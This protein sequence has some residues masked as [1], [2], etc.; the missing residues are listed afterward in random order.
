MQRT[1]DKWN[2]IVFWC[3][4]SWLHTFSV[5]DTRDCQAFDSPDIFPETLLSF[6][7]TK[8]DKVHWHDLIFFPKNFLS[9]RNPSV[10]SHRSPFGMR[11]PRTKGWKEKVI[12]QMKI[13]AFFRVSAAWQILQSLPAKIRIWGYLQRKVDPSEGIDL[14]WKFN[15]VISVQNMF[16]CA[17]LSRDYATIK[18]QFKNFLCDL[19]LIFKLRIFRYLKKWN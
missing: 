1:Q 10:V 5:S 16:Y 4:K 12:F 18:S 11:K 19:K 2:L 8:G 13:L 6:R 17:N 9:H 7:A 14:N 15:C 3:F